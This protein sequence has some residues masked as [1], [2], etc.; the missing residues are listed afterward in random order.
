M[1]KRTRTGAQTWEADLAAAR[2]LEPSYDVARGAARF[3]AS[4]AAAGATVATASAAGAL[5]K[6][7]SPGLASKAIGMLAL[8]GAVIAVDAHA[9]LAPVESPKIVLNHQAR[10]APLVRPLAPTSAPAKPALVAVTA[11]AAPTPELRRAP[12]AAPSVR[13][14]RFRGELA[15]V[16][17]ARALLSAD[18]A[19]ALA[20]ADAPQDSQA[21]A[22]EREII[23][24]RALVSLGR[25]AEAGARARDFVRRRPTSPFAPMAR[26]LLVE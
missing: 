15:G 7:M 10:Y 19:A 6:G 4:I 2:G 13:S 9:P 17:H 8:S 23:A 18:P 3:S 22:E 14:D 5:G 12:P 21:L 24:I 11:S 16:A 26:R 20:A 1:T 25:T